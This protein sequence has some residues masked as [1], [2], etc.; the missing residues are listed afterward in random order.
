MPSYADLNTSMQ[1]KAGSQLRT[2]DK[3]IQ[4]NITGWVR[5]WGFDSA[6]GSWMIV[7][8]YSYYGLVY[9]SQRYEYVN[10]GDSVYNNYLDSGI[11]TGN[12]IS[13]QDV[14]DSITSVIRRTVDLIEGRLGNRT[15]SISPCHQ[16]CHSSCHTSRGRR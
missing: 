2:F 14:I 8:G 4:L 16:S 1:S 5:V 15:F 11:Y 6:Y 13:S 12:I 3:T 7:N 10:A 9:N